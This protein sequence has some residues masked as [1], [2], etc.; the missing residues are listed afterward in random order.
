MLLPVPPVELLEP[1]PLGEPVVPD[2]LV[3]VLLGDEVPVAEVPLTGVEVPVVG[4]DPVAVTLDGAVPADVEDGAPVL[5]TGALG[6]AGVAAEVPFGLEAGAETTG[7]AVGSAGS[8]AVG[9]VPG[10]Y[11]VVSWSGS[12]LWVSGTHGVL[13]VDRG[14]RWPVRVDDEVGVKGF[15][16][17]PVAGAAE[18]VTGSAAVWL[19]LVPAAG[20]ALALLSAG[21]GP[22]A[23][24]R[25]AA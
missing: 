4:V 20:V 18:L 2:E 10:G 13:P 9:E 12:S 11:R 21:C 17:E 1:V 16:A 25:V 5:E 7:A 6:S 24:P 3:P 19:T 14:R 23:G 15:E 22:R 8:S